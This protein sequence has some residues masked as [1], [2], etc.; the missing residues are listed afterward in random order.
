[1]RGRLAPPGLDQPGQMDDGVRAA[2]Q[3]DEV[4]GR[5]VGRLE[6]RPGERAIR[7]PPR[8]RDDL[9]NSWLGLERLE[10][11]RADVSGGANHDNSH[12]RPYP[13]PTTRH[14]PRSRGAASMPFGSRAESSASELIRWIV[15]C[16]FHKVRHQ[17]FI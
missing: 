17:K 9:L 13:N 14:G 4:A 1:M 5:D 11:A 10:H 8:H 16:R 6:S 15:R 2:Q 7:S 12:N 3:R